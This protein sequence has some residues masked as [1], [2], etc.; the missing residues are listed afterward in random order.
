[1]AAFRHRSALT[2]FCLTRRLSRASLLQIGLLLLIL[3]SVFEVLQIRTWHTNQII[4]QNSHKIAQSHH[5][6][7]IYQGRIFITSLHWNNEAILP[8]WSEELVKLVEVLGRENV[9]ISIFESGSWDAS[10][11]LL[12]ELD[13][14]LVDMDVKRNI[15]LGE[16]THEEFVS[17]R[18]G[19][20]EGWVRTNRGKQEMRRIP[21]LAKLRNQ[22]LSELERL[23]EA[24]TGFDKVLFLGDVVF[25][26][27]DVLTLL[28]TNEGEYA[29]ACSLD[30]L[31]A[32]AF[33]DTFALRDSEGYEYVTQTWPF[34]RSQESRRAM[35]MME[36]VKVRSCWNGIGELLK[37]IGDMFLY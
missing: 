32:P 21:Y 25:R 18:S 24:G 5:H 9:F 15:T 1:M 35:K 28:E 34:F 16:G 31:K 4:L 12:G 10:K 7:N 6:H 33:Y 26:V 13:E 17:Q 14:K 2:L 29:A 37:L 30:F 11:S 36:P 22:G 19:K 3:Q 27:E 8:S 23:S 20:E